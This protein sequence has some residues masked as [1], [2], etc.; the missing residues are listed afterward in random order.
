M[1]KSKTLFALSLLG[2]SS[3]MYAQTVK[4][5]GNSQ[6]ITDSKNSTL[7]YEYAINDPLNTRIYTLKNGLKV[8]LSVYK[9]AP[10]IQT[11]IAVK[12][13]SK[14]DPAN[15]TGLAH[16]LEH[17]VFKGTDVY[18][19]KDFKKESVE[20][21]KIENL[22][23]SYRQT[24][25]EAQR[26]K[27]Y[28]Q[29]DS[30]SGVAAK[31]AIA[32][33]YDKLL[34]G[35]GATGTNA[36]TSLDK[37]VY[38]N[39]IPSNQI[40]NWLKIEAERFRKPVLRLFHTELEAVYEEKNR[41]LDND[42][43]KVFEALFSGLFT[44]HTYGTQTTIGTIEHLKNP[45]MVE[46]N[47]FYN[48]YYVPNNMA[49]IM[50][51]D[52]DPDKVIVEIEKN[53]GKFTPKPYDEYKFQPEAPITQKVVKEVIGPDPMNVNLGWRLGGK[54][55]LDAD[56]GVIVS[57][58]IYNGTA[59]LID[60]NLNQAQK[61]LNSYGFFDPFKDYS[62]FFIGGNPKEGQSL[63]EVE[64]LLL[65]QLDLIK[66]GNFPD[67]LL[68]AVIT[69]IKYDKTKE[70]EDNQ[71]RSRE[72]LDA[73]INDIKWQNNVN[74]LERL[75]KITKQEIVD[76]ANK[77]F[78][79]TNYVVIYK[80]IGEDK[81]VQKVEKPAITPVELDRDNSSPFVKNIIKSVPATIEPK[82]LDYDK[83][84]LKPTLKSNV[85]L[86]YNKNTENKLFQMYYKFDMGS[87]NDKLLPIVIKYIK[88]LASE[89]ISAEQFNQ[90]LYKLGSSFD[91]FIDKE[92]TWV[93][94]EGLNDN[95]DKTVQLFEK[96]LAKPLVVETVLKN[97]IEDFKKE[98]NDNKL[99]KNL[100]L[101]NGMVS[102][103]K[104]GA[105]N[106]FTYV[107]TDEEL[108]NIST[109]EIKN[110]IKA[111]LTYEHKILYYGPSEVEDVKT[112]LNTNHNVPEKL[113]P[114]PEAYNFIEKQFDKTVYVVD[115]DMKQ[116]EIILLGNGTSFDPNQVPIISL[117]N[118]YFGG[119]MSGVVFQDLRESKAL[120]YSCYSSFIQPNKL[121]KKYFNISYIGSQAD[122]LS[123]A[124][125]GMNNLLNELPKADASFSAAKESLIAETRTQR[126]TKANILFNYLAAQKL[127]LNYDIRKTVF[128]KTKLLTFDDVKN[129]YNQNIKGKSNTILVLG[130]K[131]ELDIKALE[132]YGTV[133]FLTL[134]EVFGF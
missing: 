17:M 94:L 66:K 105:I 93:I 89:E 32:N 96:I 127:G 3:I 23:E 19:T 53:F 51:G 120:A 59:G 29:I 99:Q 24:K 21:K 55:T 9:D 79:E 16:Y 5:G 92:N 35:I 52:F 97:V 98:R 71:S 116:A 107:L 104:Y 90:E 83:D 1:I 113:I 48:K 80:R 123:E 36:Y 65:G 74:T 28:H 39:D 15:A 63:E 70:L 34:A 10:R 95:F 122:K 42:Q 58:L 8:Y 46:I 106:P 112:I 110:K 114:I 100:I 119:N 37:T 20:I 81:S 132:K 131:D 91:V 118:S 30:I 78:S 27:I 57:S 85:Q 26:K 4:P 125:K 103:A 115:Y 73:F 128:D 121:S 25:D 72:M 134:K 111:L 22:Y 31:Y 43:N 133:K 49:I 109:T 130:K 44:N 60:L 126:I 87:N 117:Y 86:L 33:E 108:N 124:I 6:P 61:V 14:N 62:I 129:F 18:G 11:F 75:S 68:Q 50:S 7:N 47:K 82:F 56:L 84:I 2:V 77:N 69:D 76:F 38:V 67:W 41:G 54:N 45:S 12:A 64:K 102:Y 88:Y 40:D 101:N 13:G